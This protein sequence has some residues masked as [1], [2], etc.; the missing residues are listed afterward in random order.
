MKAVQDVIQSGQFITGPNVR[1]FESEVATYLGARHAVSLNSGTDALVIALKSLGIGP[2]DEVITT[3]FTFFATAEAICQVGATPVFADIQETT[4]NLDPSAIEPLITSRTKAILPVHLFGLSADM[5]KIMEIANRHGLKVV[6]DVAQ[7][8]GGELCGRKLGTFGDAGCFS[9]FPTKNLGAYG[10]GGLL[11]TNDDDVAL[12]ARKLRTHGGINK[13]R[14][15]ML[16]YNSRLDEIQA[17]ILRVKLP[18]IDRWNDNRRRIAGIYRE[19]LHDLDLLVQ[20][21]ES[22]NSR[23]VYHQFTIRVLGGMRN[24]LKARLEELGVSTMIYYSA[25]VHKLPVFEGLYDD[26][27]LEKAERLADEVLSL[28]IWPLMPQHYLEQ[29]IDAIRTAVR[30]L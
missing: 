27:R 11:V 25:P 17:A 3:P 21:V 23:H 8:F 15:E 7:A 6:E 13:Y 28:P 10:D 19:A 29:T 26:V 2:G 1:A 9:F 16:G 4:Y 12:A 24:A 5:V 20:P 22:P 14:N 18:Y 30:A